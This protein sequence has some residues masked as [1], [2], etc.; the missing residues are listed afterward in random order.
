MSAIMMLDYLN[1]IF[2]NCGV[3][4]VYAGDN[5]GYAKNTKLFVIMKNTNL[6]A[7]LQERLTHYCGDKFT[8][9]VLQTNESPALEKQKLIW[10]DGEWR[11]SVL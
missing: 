1:S 9:R 3:H 8:L 7:S 4:E 10:Y 5:W 11:D 2:I 6:A